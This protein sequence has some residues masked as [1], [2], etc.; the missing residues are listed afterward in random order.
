MLV[1]AVA[2]IFAPA[3][4]I[5]SRRR[6]DLQVTVVGDEVSGALDV[7][8]DLGASLSGEV[9][10]ERIYRGGTAGT[11]QGHEVG[12]ET[13]NVGRGCKF[14]SWIPVYNKAECWLGDL[15]MLVPLRTAVS[16]SDLMP[17]L[18]TSTPGA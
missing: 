12:G 11:L 5:L 14:V 4:I 9:L 15:P 7:V 17:T 8:L 16:V 18:R 1:N 13:G 2:T 10:D 6:T 3:S